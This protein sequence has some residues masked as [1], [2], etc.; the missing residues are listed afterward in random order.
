MAKCLLINPSYKASYGKTKVSIIDPI[1]PTVALLSLA[2]AAE[3]NGHKVDILDLS[4]VRYDWRL[5]EDKIRSFCPDV[6]GI[7]GTTPLVNQ[8]R[9]ISVMIKRKFSDILVIAGGV[10]VSALPSE[11]LTE[12]MLDAV[13]VGEGELTIAD[14]LNGM[15]LKDVL[16][17]YYRDKNGAICQNPPRNFVSNL[18]D[19][20]FPAWHLFNAAMYKNK[21]SRLLARRVPA[22]MIEF[23]R[24]CIYKCDFCASKMTMALG[25]RKK[26]PERCAK[27]VELLYQHGWREFALTDDIF[28]SDVRWAKEVCRKIIE[29]GLDVAWTCTNGIRVESA[30]LELFQLMRKAGCY[31]VSFGFETGNDDVLKAFGKGGKATLTEGIKAVKLARKAH[32]DVCGFFMLGLSPDT[33]ASM[34]DTINYARKLSLDMLKFGIAVPFPG[35]KMFREY[36]QKG[37]IKSFNWD[38]YVI[39]TSKPLFAHPNLSFDTVQKYMRLAYRKAILENPKFIARRIIHSILS[40]ELF[41]DIYYFFKFFFAPE[42]N[43][44]SDSASYFAKNQWPQFSYDTKS[45]KFVDYRA[46]KNTDPT[47]K[48]SSRIENLSILSMSN[49]QQVKDIASFLCGTKALN[50]SPVEGGRNSRIYRIEKGDNVFALKFFRPDKDGKRERFEAETTALALFAENGIGSTPRVIEKDRENNC[51]LMEWIEGE[52]VDRYNAQEIEALV[53]FIQAVHDIS[54]KGLNQKIRRA[55]EACLNGNEVV[56]QINLRLSRLD[57]SKSTYP[58]LREFI[59]TEFTPAFNEISQWSQRQYQYFGLSFDENISFEQ[60][61]LS[62]VDLGF[63]NVLRKNNKLYF[64]DFEFF[65]WDDPVKLVADTLQHPGMT[66]NDENKQLLFSNFVKIYGQDE[67]FLARLKLLYP[68]FGLKWCMIMLNQFL[69]G[70]KQPLTKGVIEKERQLERVRSLV[71]SIHENYQEFSYDRKH[72][73]IS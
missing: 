13:V 45:L 51:V 34:Q 19:L 47:A 18:D 50:V 10:H 35:T 56:R 29:T 40:L 23:S 73:E 1:F 66:L 68:L 41:W 54:R 46:A 28:T 20:P 42:T 61:T 30:D 57:A 48:V 72:S 53:S 7:T 55:R 15:A 17:I 26:S 62:V 60:Q 36:Y 16:G 2:A 37:L 63:H 5:V 52:W 31:R 21:I 43:Q 59:N 22:G 8:I 44:E 69:P 3:K 58:E 70:Y 64:L 38:D 11:I 4:Y 39:Y 67:M 6:V 25:Y 71:K 32:I 65:G 12:S 9:D 27:E 33:E 14:I 49:D 24:G